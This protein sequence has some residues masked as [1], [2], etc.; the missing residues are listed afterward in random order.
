[1]ERDPWEICLEACQALPESFMQ[2]D[3]QQEP[4][5]GRDWANFRE[6]PG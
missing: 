6:C 3:C 5:Q 2:E 1:M 4:P